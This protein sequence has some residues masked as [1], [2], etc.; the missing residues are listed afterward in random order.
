MKREAS[1]DR[2][3]DPRYTAA[4]PLTIEAS[5]T[6]EVVS[7]QERKSGVFAETDQR[8]GRDCAFF[9]TPVAAPRYS[10][11]SE[12]CSFPARWAMGYGG[13]ACRRSERSS[14]F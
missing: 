8:Q 7:F 3:R 4:A 14:R 11:R 1:I 13:F 9:Q 6:R 12:S 2:L 5:I 10:R